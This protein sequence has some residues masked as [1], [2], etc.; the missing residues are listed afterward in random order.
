MI[1]TR[2]FTYTMYCGGCPRLSLHITVR[3]L[4]LITRN[5]STGQKNLLRKFLDIRKVYHR[6]GDFRPL[7]F[8]NTLYAL[9]LYTGRVSK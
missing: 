6:P 1:T 4:V 8:Q 7:A 3:I 5:G 2:P 9:T